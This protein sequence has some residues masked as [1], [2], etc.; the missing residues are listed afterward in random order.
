MK[1][2][3]VTHSLKVGGAE[4]SLELLVRN[5]EGVV[6]DL[7]VP[8]WARQS[9]DA[10]R[11]AFGPSLRRV[12]RTWL[13]YDRCYR[14]RPPTYR[15]IH[16]YAGALLWRLGGRRLDKRV[17]REGYD[18]IHLNSVI[19][20]PMVRTGLPF[21]VH[22]REIV[23][24][25]HERVARSLAAARGAIFIDL[26]TKAPFASLGTPNMVMNNP[27]AMGD[28]PVPADAAA[29]LRAN[30]ADVTVFAIIG[31]LI[32][33]K[34]VDRVIRAFRGVRRPNARLLVVGRGRDR[35]RLERLARG[36]DRIVFWGEDPQIER[37]Y[38][39]TDYVIRGEATFA[40]GRTI[41]EGLYA[42]TEVI[43]PASPDDAVFDRERF[44]GRIHSYTPGDEADLRAVM[45]RLADRKVIRQ[46]VR[47][48]VADYAEKFLAFVRESTH[49]RDVTTDD[50]GSA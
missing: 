21:I 29:R 32:P 23:E 50:R 30:P 11:A 19:L 20:H 14:G 27:I 37:V 25:H 40:V 49:A 17:A 48:N 12:H 43:I 35:S 24:L 18:A 42:G 15:A 9:D 47:S 34:G 2:L 26:A 31:M 38:A 45:E 22:V 3:F 6:C 10:I 7:I 46:P 13:P 1:L 8:R 44:A 28:S 36:D 16:R 5:L 41:Y 4:R 39:L 33:E